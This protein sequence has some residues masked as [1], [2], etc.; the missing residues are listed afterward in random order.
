MSRVHKHAGGI[1]NCT[2]PETGSSP[3]ELVVSGSW[4]CDG[5]WRQQDVLTRSR[6]PAA[7]AT[8]ANGDV[9]T[10]VADSRMSWLH[11]ERCGGRWFTW[12]PAWG[13]S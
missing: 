1:M 7:V 3:A 12:L 8:A 11:C 4:V 10:A 2:C 9:L 13:R 5:C 6:H